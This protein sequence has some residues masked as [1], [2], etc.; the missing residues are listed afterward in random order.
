MLS[1]FLQLL[2]NILGAN[3]Y[4]I[5]QLLYEDYMIALL[6]SYFPDSDYIQI[7]VLYISS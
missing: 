4:F 7:M 5:L 1:Y 3:L 2:H 6:T